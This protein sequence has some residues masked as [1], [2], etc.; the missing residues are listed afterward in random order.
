VHGHAERLPDAPQ[1]RASHE[2]ADVVRLAGE[3]FSRGNRLSPEQRRLLRDLGRCRT[4]ALGGHVETCQVC[5]ASRPSYN[6]CRN[7]HCPKCQA[8]RQAQWVDGRER[9]ILPTHHFHVVFTL[10]APLRPIAMRY[11]QV[12]FD[13]L[14]ACAAETLLDLGRDPD[15]LNAQLAVT[16]V[17][18]TWKRDL[19]WHPHVHCIV[20]GGGL[21]IGGEKW[22]PSSKRFLFPVLVLGEPRQYFA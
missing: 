10:P 20:S 14:F 8:V 7:R 16:G 17:L 12:V 5:G 9:R 4:A 1:N 11:R 6:S 15:R 22:T 3:A 21:D 19:G 2:V 18:H 13:M